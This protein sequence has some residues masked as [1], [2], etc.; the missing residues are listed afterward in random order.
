M[1]K[2]VTI[3]VSARHVHLSKED[4]YTLFGNGYILTKRNDLS[5]P[6]QFAA[7]ETV[8]LVGPKDKIE[9]V[10]IL[11]PPRNYTQV[12]ISKTDGYKLGISAP[13]RDSGDLE[14]SAKGILLGPQGKVEL[15][16]GIIYAWRHIHSSVD[17]AQELGL[18]DKDIVSVKIEGERALT[19]GNVL[20]RVDP[21]FK[22]AFHIDTDEANAAGVINGDEGIL[23]TK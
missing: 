9:K 17:D 12:E 13:I 7:E 20:V 19:F 6:G 18:K 5:Q 23:L 15:S 11:G 8:I 2:K 3:E 1:G 10:R 21:N 14:N 22:L 4:L 16:E